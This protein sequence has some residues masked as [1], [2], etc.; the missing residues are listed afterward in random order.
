MKCFQLVKTVL[1][2]VYAIIP[3]DVVS[4]DTAIRTQLSYLHQKYMNLLNNPEPID[5]RDPVTRFAYLYRYVTSHANLVYTLID[6]SKYLPALFECESL[7]IT[8]IGGGPGSDLLGILKYMMNTG[9]NVPIHCTLYDREQAWG[10]SWSDVDQKVGPGFKTSTF[11]QP[12][13]VTDAETWSFHTKYLNSDLFTM[14]Y[15]L[16]EV[17]LLRE[18][19]EPF[20]MNLFSRARSGSM[21]LFIDNNSPSF[22]EWFDMLANRCGLAI[23]E[24]DNLVMKL[25]LDEQ[26]TDL[27]EYFG[28]F[29]FPKMEPN[30]AYRVCFKA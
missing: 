30:V 16:S 14:I 3:G 24:N 5:Y 26:K 18:Q 17:Y 28:K 29:G 7:K 25:P 19:A 22:Y 2:E 4:K 23:V 6:S 10:E 21:F 15:F 27:G 8:C 12:F 11:F 1:D 9:R 20:F 13:D